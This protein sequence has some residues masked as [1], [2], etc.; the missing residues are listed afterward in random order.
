MQVPG[1]SIVRLAYPVTVSTSQYTRIISTN[2]LTGYA[3]TLPPLVWI[4]GGVDLNVKNLLNQLIIDTFSFVNAIAF[5]TVF[6][7]AGDLH[8]EFTGDVSKASEEFLL[9]FRFILAF[10]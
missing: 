7:A 10:S 3:T 6:R 5:Q 8:T 1:Q 2:I 9:G 4:F